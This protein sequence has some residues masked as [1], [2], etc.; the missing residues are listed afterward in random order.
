MILELDF[1]DNLGLFPMTQTKITSTEVSTT[2]VPIL[3]SQ[4]KK[5]KK[6]IPLILGLLV[7]VIGGI[8]YAVWLQQKQSAANILQVS[9]RIEGYETNIGVKRSGR[10]ESVAVREGAFVKQGQKLVRL[11]NSN[12]QLLAEQL[13]GAQARLRSAQSDAQ[14]AISDV[15]SAQ[16]DIDQV[17]SQINEAKFNLQ[18]SRGDTQGRIGQAKSNVAGSKAQLAQAEALVKESLAEVRLDKINR[19]R[20]AKLVKEGAVNQQQFDQSQTTLDTAI[21]TLDSRK[22]AVNASREQLNANIGVLV[23]TKTTVFNPRI[24]NS[25]LQTLFRKKQQNYS[26]LKSAESK[27]SSAQAKV[28]DALASIQQLLTQ[29]EDSKRDLNVLSPLDGV[30][31]AR[32]VE[33]G[34]VVSSQTNILTI[35]DPKNIYLRGFIPEG[36][37]GKVRV[38]QRSKIFIDSATDKP[39]KGKVIAI[40]PQASFTPENIYFQKDRVKQVVG[41]RIHIE[42]PPGCLNPNR[43]YGESN[44]P[45]A[46]IGM[47]AD[48]EIQLQHQGK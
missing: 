24:R 1:F 28:K 23:Q 42:N 18:Q 20:Y 48:A 10:I 30:V 31:T 41:V 7:V 33:P 34:A 9:G 37:I 26:Q 16:S 19:D 47:P 2:D 36:D 15:N 14:Q 21:A 27:A 13:R 45:C 12:D 39:L 8:T 3:P 22:A 46:K 6:P 4:S 5:N 38:G 43:P 32:S 25:Q 29:I 17:N 40:D 35:V 11:D 44:L